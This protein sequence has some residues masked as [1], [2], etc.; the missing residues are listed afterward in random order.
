MLLTYLCL[1][2]GGMIGIFY[3]SDTKKISLC[4][5]DRVDRIPSLPSLLEYGTMYAS[6]NPYLSLPS[7]KAGP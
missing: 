6:T 3:D 4:H 1:V 5:G 7:C 2:M